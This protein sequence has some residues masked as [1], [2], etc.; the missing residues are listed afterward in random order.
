MKFTISTILFFFSTILKCRVSFTGSKYISIVVKPSPPAIFRDFPSSQLKLCT[1]QTVTPH[2]PQSLSSREP[3]FTFSPCEFDQ[4]SCGA[5]WYLFF[6]IWH[7]SLSIMSSRFIHVVACITI[8]FFCFLRLNNI[9]HILF[10]YSSMDRYLG[11][12]TFLVF[13]NNN[14][15]NIG[16]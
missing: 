16:V 10:I 4:S 3:C 15:G 12:F 14:A 1:R 6:C 9:H 13:V 2:F 7:F 11:G 5:I 8:S